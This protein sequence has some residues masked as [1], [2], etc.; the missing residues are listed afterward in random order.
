MKNKFNDTKYY[1]EVTTTE[2]NNNVSKITNSK[3]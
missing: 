3:I 2:K 1:I